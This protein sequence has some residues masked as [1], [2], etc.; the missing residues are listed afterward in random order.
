VFAKYRNTRIK[1]RKNRC[2]NEQI[3]E[4][5]DIQGVITLLVFASKLRRKKYEKQTSVSMKLTWSK[6]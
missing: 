1:G 3:E 5:T 4:E 6:M 2:I